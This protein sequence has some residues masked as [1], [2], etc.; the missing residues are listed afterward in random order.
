MRLSWGGKAQATF[1]MQVRQLCNERSL[2]NAAAS[3]P[4]MPRRTSLSRR[5]SGLQVAQR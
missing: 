4:R 2:R 1:G 5:D 3:A